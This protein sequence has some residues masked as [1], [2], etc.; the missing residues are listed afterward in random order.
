MGLYNVVSSCV[1][2]GLHYIHPTVQPI[3]VGDDEA[4]PLVKAGSLTHYGTRGYFK[5]TAVPK[6][7]DDEELAPKPRRRKTKD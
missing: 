7:S 3:E 2:N 1:V 6:A 4:A 5:Y